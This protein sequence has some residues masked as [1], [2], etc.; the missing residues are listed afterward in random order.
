MSTDRKYLNHFISL[1][2]IPDWDAF[3]AALTDIYGGPP[4]HAYSKMDGLCIVSGIISKP[5]GLLP[6][7]RARGVVRERGE[8]PQ[9]EPDLG[10]TLLEAKPKPESSEGSDAE[11]VTERTSRDKSQAQGTDISG[12]LNNLAIGSDTA[13]TAGPR[14]LEAARTESVAGSVAPSM[15][16]SFPDSGSSSGDSTPQSR[17][18]APGVENDRDPASIPAPAS[19]VA[20]VDPASIPAPASSIGSVDPA[21]IPAPA[22]STASVQNSAR[23]SRRA[24]R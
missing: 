2:L 6:L 8:E 17:G 23:R 5:A 1:D 22:S 4:N 15:P 3:V 9:Q 13:S 14:P 7:L 11:T 19:S 12:W 21:S 10:S 24:P 16:G 20:S 18:R